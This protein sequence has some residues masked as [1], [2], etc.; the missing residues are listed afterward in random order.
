[1]IVDW[2]RVIADLQR[3]GLD[4]GQLGR[5]LDVSRRTIGHWQ[6]GIHEPRYSKGV[7]LL[8]IYRSVVKST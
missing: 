1:M 8:E 3:A 6:C 4:H 7:A 5:E 2:F